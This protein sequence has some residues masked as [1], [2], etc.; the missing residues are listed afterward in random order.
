VLGR[1]ISADPFVPDPLST[2][3]YNRYS[4]VENNPL[5]YTDPSGFTPYFIC[6]ASFVTRSYL[7]P[8]GVIIPWSEGNPGGTFPGVGFGGWG[9][10]CG[11]FDIPDPPKDPPKIPNEPQTPDST[12][13]FIGWLATSGHYAKE[14]GKGAVESMGAS[15]WQRPFNPENPGFGG[16]LN[17]EE[18][19]G[20]YQSP[21]EPPQ[22]SEDQLARDLGATAPVIVG[23]ITGKALNT[24]FG[25]PRAGTKG[26]S[27]EWVSA[28]GNRYHGNSTRSSASGGDARAPMNPEMQQALDA[29]KNPSRSHGHCCEIDAM[30]KALN[31][32]ESIRGGKMGPVRSNET[33]LEIPPCSTC[34]EVKKTLGSE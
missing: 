18:M 15:Y 3:S 12:H 17:L 29:V 22:T 5:T 23:A 27:G 30:N 2:Q 14:Y 10:Q 1:F 31:A 19:F 32:G 8:G 21:F 33:G 6:Y 20:P 7:V 4:Y 24:K 28:S 26:T 13:S 16:P 34:R 11:Y 9:V 25:G